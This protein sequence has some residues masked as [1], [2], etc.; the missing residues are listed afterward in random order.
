M[1]VCIVGKFYAWAMTYLDNHK[2]ESS[3][4][5]KVGGP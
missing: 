4:N 2:Q 3:G 5:P 1:Y